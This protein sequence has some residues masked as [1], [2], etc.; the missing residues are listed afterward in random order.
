MINETI[1]YF[2]IKHTQ[3]IKERIH[4]IVKAGKKKLMYF[5]FKDW[6]QLY[7]YVV[8]G[9]QNTSIECTYCY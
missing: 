6:H 3:T 8:F 5:N 4:K 7:V 9:T 1:V 2:S